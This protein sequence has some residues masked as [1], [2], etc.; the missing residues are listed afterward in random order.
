MA[1]II[2]KTSNLKNIN[3]FLIVN[4]IMLEQGQSLLDPHKYFFNKTYKN[5]VLIF[6]EKNILTTKVILQV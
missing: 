2:K 3:N 1:S 6:G 4:A 5:C